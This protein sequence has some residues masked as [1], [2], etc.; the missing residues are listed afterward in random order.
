MLLRQSQVLLLCKLQHRALRQLV[1]AAFAHVAFLT[2]VNAKEYVEHDTYH[3][4]KVNHQCPSHRL[5]WLTVVEY[6][7]DHRQDDH[8]LIDY[9]YDIQP[10]HRFPLTFDVSTQFLRHGVVQALDAH[11]LFHSL[12]IVVLAHLQLG[13]QLLFEM[14]QIVIAEIEHQVKDVL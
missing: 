6:H 9:E 7:M 11:I 1:H 10:T 13:Q 5:G 4:Y 3:W 8:N 12:H 2:G 14:P